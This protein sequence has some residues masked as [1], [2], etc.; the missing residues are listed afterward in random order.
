MI[1]RTDKGKE[2]YNK[3]PLKIEVGFKSTL[4]EIKTIC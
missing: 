4:E 2:K 3:Y 1:F